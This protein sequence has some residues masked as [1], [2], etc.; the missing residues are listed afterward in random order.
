MNPRPFVEEIARDLR[1]GRA[2]DLAC[3]DGRNAVWLAERGWTVTAVD[4]APAF[5]HP[6]VK[7]V[8]ADLER[9]EFTIEPGAWDLIVVSYYLQR[10]LFGPVLRGLAAGGV[11]IFIVL[12]FEPGRE[13]SRF[14]MQPGELRA[15][16]ACEHV[17][18]YREGV[19][20][21]G[22][23]AVAEIAVRRRAAIN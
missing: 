4:R 21:E 12:L 20:Q 6:K 14:R 23:H 5:T 22:G 9:Q 11:A 7:I 3:G 2:L 8:T 16:F 13:A 10:D 1:P 15:A 17:A 18:A 19:P